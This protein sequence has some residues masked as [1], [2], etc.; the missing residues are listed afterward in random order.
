MSDIF[1]DQ[2]IDE[3]QTL[4]VSLNKFYKF[5]ST[6][7]FDICRGHCL[8][9]NFLEYLQM[10]RPS[11]NIAQRLKKLQMTNKVLNDKVKMLADENQALR[12]INIQSQLEN[13]KLK[14]KLQKLE[15]SFYDDQDQ[16]FEVVQNNYDNYEAVEYVEDSNIAFEEVEEKNYVTKRS[17][18]E[19]FDESEMIEHEEIQERDDTK[20]EYLMDD[21]LTTEDDTVYYQKEEDDVKHVTRYVVD[22]NYPPIDPVEA[23][24]HV[25]DLAS[26]KGA[27]EKLKQIP[28][29]RQGD[30][31]FINKCLE[32]LFDRMVLANSST[33][34]QKFQ[35]KYD[36]APKP[37]LDPKK[38]NICRQAFAYRLNSEG[39]STRDDRFKLFHGH[40]NSKIQNTRKCVKKQKTPIRGFTH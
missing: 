19:A 15:S 35:G 32:F 13:F 22:T 6:N 18:S 20:E 36:V 17:Y 25:A 29:G 7:F 21:E 1:S 4:I 3:Q 23:Y 16:P 38:L 26:K 27:I 5:A 34:G 33:R 40:V 10:N 39:F 31:T 28:K 9:L 14:Q 8:H 2:M 12:D 30:S 11:G 24:Q 37:A